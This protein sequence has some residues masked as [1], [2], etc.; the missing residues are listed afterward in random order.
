M[1]FIMKNI[2]LFEPNISNL[3]KK[4]VI[5]S[6]SKNQISS[7]GYF[8]DLFIHKVKKITN[9]KYN[10]ATSS[11][12]SA[13]FLALK[14]IGIK[15]DEIVITQSYTFAATTNAIILNNSIPL[16]LDVSL[17]DLNLDFNQLDYFLKKNKFKS[18]GYTYHKKT[19]KKITCICFVLTLGIIPDLDKINFFKKKYKLKIIFDAACALGHK[20]KNQNLSKYC[21]VAIYSLNGNKNFTAGAGGLLST[22][23]FK[24]YNFAKIFA[25]NGKRFMAYNYQ[26]TGFNFNMSSLN[27]A[28]ALAQVKRFHEININKVKIRNFY[29]K[30]LSPIKLFNTDFIWGKYLPWINFFLT[31]TKEEKKRIISTLRK[32]NVM[33]NNFWLPM[34]K[35]PIKKHFILTKYPNTNYIY[36]RILVLP[37]STFLLLKNIKKITNII[38]KI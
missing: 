28:L 25:N 10:L 26:T 29:K 37:S 4:I 36:D 19:K 7:Y 17:N 1:Y 34:H 30:Y 20:Y 12:S 33:S 16:L 31:K 18:R 38:K 22:N 21:D 15:K 14:S 2:S 6:L 5:K 35:H 9:S 32:N 27:G 3:E 11:G 24:Y 23:I 8:T 13:L